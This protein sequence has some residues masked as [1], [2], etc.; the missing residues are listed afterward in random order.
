MARIDA[1]ALPEDRGF[2]FPQVYRHQPLQL[3]ERVAGTEGVRPADGRVHPHADQSF[4]LPFPHLFH[5]PDVGVV[6][7]PLGKIAVAEVILLRRVLS[8][9][10]LQQA[11]DVLGSVTPPV[12]AFRVLRLRRPFLVIGGE[13]DVVELRRFEVAG[14]NVE[15]QAV[16]GGTLDVGFTAQGVD[17]SAGDADVAQEHLEQRHRADI[18]AAVGGLGDP[19][20]IED[21]AGFVGPPRPAERAGD[22]EK[23]F[24]PGSG[25]GADGFDVVAGVVFLQQLVDAARVAH[26]RVLARRS[27]GI[28]GV[29]PR[30]RIVRFL[31]IVEGTEH[32]VFEPVGVA[33]DE[34]GV[35]VVTHVLPVNELVLQGVVDESAEEGDV[36]ARAKLGVDVRLG[37]R[38][39]VTRIDGNQLCAVI[40]RLLDPFERNGMILRRVAPYG[41][42]G[43]GILQ[44]YP[45]VGHGTTTE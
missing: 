42:N 8:V 13:I 4:D 17:P 25:Y 11:G 16:I 2:R 43:I 3:A 15:Q 40:Q 26:G 10:T 35:G 37:G 33:D 20:R 45:V 21:G 38:S 31:L 9:P 36:G 7:H 1:G 29:G 12:G 30:F 6:P 28:E 32:S 19:H 24:H 44:V 34:R 41:E 14:K 39:R 18:L 22:L 27:V 5:D 23:I